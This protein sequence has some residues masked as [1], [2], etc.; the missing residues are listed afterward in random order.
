MN[1][2]SIFFTFK[3]LVCI[4]ISPITPILL[5]LWM[6]WI[7]N[8]LFLYDGIIKVLTYAN[9]KSCMFKGKEYAYGEVVKFMYAN[10][11]IRMLLCVL[12][13][14]SLKLSLKH[15]E[16]KTML[17]AVRQILSLFIYSM[18]FSQETIIPK[19]CKIIW[20]SRTRKNG[21]IKLTSLIIITVTLISCTKWLFYC[22][23]KIHFM[24]IHKM[25][26]FLFILLL[27]LLHYFQYSHYIMCE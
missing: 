9:I 13:I 25:Y 22:R 7:L 12:C 14:H 20:L 23:N 5:S 24:V 2:K 27:K 26:C 8:F 19:T 4:Q 21:S 16:E 1:T 10:S 11:L 15:N 3:V 6:Y 18:V 17:F